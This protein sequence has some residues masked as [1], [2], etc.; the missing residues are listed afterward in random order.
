[1]IS[2]LSGDVAAVGSD[3]KADRL[4]PSNYCEDCRAHKARSPRS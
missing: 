3:P 4:Q 1:M 2:P